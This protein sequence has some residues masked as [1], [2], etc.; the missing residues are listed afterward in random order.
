MKSVR[1]ERLKVESKFVR[2]SGANHLASP[3][4]TP[5]GVFQVAP[6]TIIHGSLL[7]CRPSLMAEILSSWWTL[8]CQVV[9]F[10]WWQGRCVEL[11]IVAI[12]NT[13]VNGIL[14]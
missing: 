10:M 8:W 11:T 3:N 1:K 7:L 12:C 13:K 14:A 2:A 6:R 5:P 9:S 4:G